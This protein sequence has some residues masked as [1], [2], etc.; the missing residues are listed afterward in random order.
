MEAEALRRGVLE[1]PH[2]DVEPAAIE[3]EAAVAGR[4]FVIAVMQV[5]RAELRL[6]E[7]LVLDAHRPG[8]RGAGGLLVID[9]ATILGLDADDAIH[10]GSE[11]RSGTGA[12]Q[13]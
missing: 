4:L 11:R 3:Q 7:N 1:V 5:D 9:E 2:V 13:G 6:A 12:G 10:G 8:I